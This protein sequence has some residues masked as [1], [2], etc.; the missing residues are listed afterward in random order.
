MRPQTA[1]PVNTT[2]WIQ[3]YIGA[4]NH[5]VKLLSAA[6]ATTH[7][8]LAVAQSDEPAS[9]LPKPAELEA[10]G[11][12]VG[13]IIFDRQNVFDTTKP[14]ENN[15]LYRL[16]N[17]WHIV[18]RESVVRNQL[19]F[20]TGDT[21]SARILEE[22]ERILRQNAYFYDA[23]VEPVRY[24]NGV[25]DIRVRTRDL[26]TLMPGLSVSRS[27]GENRTRVT[28]SER[29]LLGQGVSLRFNYIENVDRESTSVDYFDRNLGK[30][31]ISVFAK[32]ADS[33]DG[34]TVDFRLIRPFYELDARWSAGGT[35]L[36]DTREVAYY[37]LGN[38]A[39]EYAVD[40][41]YHTATYGWSAGLRD[42]WVRRWSG[43]FVYDDNQ[44]MPAPDG[45]LPV[46]LP[47]DRK[48]VYPFVG[49]ELLEDRFESTSNRDQ[50]ERTEDFFMGTRLRSS[51]GYATEGLGADR[52][53]LIY[54]LE[55][56]RGFGSIEKKALLLS[57]RF[58]GRIDEGSSAN[59][60]LTLNA[61]YYNQITDKRLFFMTLDAS[62]GNN[63]DLDNLVD[64]GG[65]SG[66]RGYPL[67]Y[68]TGDSRL[69]FTIE[70]R[71]FTDWYPF[72]LFRV[73]GAVFAD[74]GRVWGENPVGG[75][76][77]G[78]LTD[79]GLGLRLAPTRASG[80][81]VIHIDIAF[82]LDGD[83]TIDDVQFLIESKR[84]F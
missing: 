2:P 4:V 13:D 31:W 75:E 7:M 49:F 21:F 44:F 54:L 29:N 20:Q 79:L 84:S 46:L 47:A 27:G 81:D 83:P 10:A 65:D 35:F 48:L 5:V 69:L 14:G 42:G 67:R 70:Q 60:E 74:A 61:R 78:W 72:R 57:S 30:S 36:D 24:E 34:D 11:A 58:S 23:R 19:L 66:L 26:W 32:Y 25:V 82:P 16:A 15:A 77:L 8:G 51:I 59:Q 3:C 80:R 52:E 18:T 41:D 28:I 1:D 12:I 76:Q 63:L 62:A 22:S 33:S 38:E 17:R 9:E 50:M 40:R 45:T 73:G 56:S 71:Y 39:A 6:V 55:A 53:S 37:D 43:G 64:I 68:Q